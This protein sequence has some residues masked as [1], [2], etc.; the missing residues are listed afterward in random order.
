MR[1]GCVVIGLSIAAVL[2]AAPRVPYAT[3]LG[4]NAGDS[5]SQIASDS[6]GNYYVVS[7][8]SSTN[9]PALPANQS[10]GADTDVVVSKF[11]AA[12]VLVYSTVLAGN[13][14][15]SCNSIVADTDGSVYLGCNTSSPNFP[16]PAGSVIGTAVTGTGVVKLNPSGVLVASAFLAAPA[17]QGIAGITL[18]SGRN[19]WVTGNTAGFP[20]QTGAIQTG[21]AGDLDIFVAKFNSGLTQMTYFTYLGSSAADGGNRIAVDAAGNVY[22]SAFGGSPSFP[23]GTGKAFPGSGVFVAKL[24]PA[25]NK[26][27]YAS[28][29]SGGSGG[30]G[31][32]VDGNDIWICGSVGPT[33][34]TTADA[35]QPASGGG[36]DTAL[37]RLSAQDGTIRYASYFGGNGNEFANSMARDPDGNIIVFGNTT[38]TDLR[39]T[40]DAIRATLAN[41]T[42]AFLYQ[43]DAGGRLLFSTY[44]GGSTG[45]NFGISVALDKLGN[46]IVFGITAATDFP[47]SADAYQGQF[48]GGANDEYIA[49][50]ELVG[51][52]DP[53]LELTAIQNA[54]SFAGGA[55][56][57]G[58]II[59]IYPRNVGP[60]G[61]V[62]A[63]LTPD[64]RIAT[65]IGAT[66]VLFDDVPSPM[67]YTIN[68][69]V[70]LVVPYSVQGKALTRVVVEYNGVKS[71]PFA[72]PVT[73]AAP[74]IFTALSGVGQAAALNENG[75]FNTAVNRATRG[76]IL[77]F[78]LTGEGQT[79]PAGVDGRLNEFSR[80]E[81]FPA[82]VLKPVVTIGGQP[83]EILFSAG[84]PNY[85]AGLMQFN[86]RIP[87]GIQP[88]A[89]VPLTVTIGTTA[90]PSG[91]TLAIQ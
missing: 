63:A 62:T 19:V 66:R 57:P 77:V 32:V 15:D 90:T 20:N 45:F 5:A 43:V 58:E 35:L 27:L 52:A 4:G 44:L 2:A 74:G 7:V 37:V 14:A 68:G 26:L 69:Q 12:N 88:G 10:F 91:V 50:I 81:D 82:P 80:L 9:F 24:D 34:T 59:T 3:Y 67:V 42:S 49:R 83:A 18:D 25:A 78:F 16:R 6:S 70:S 55:V 41:P 47:V 28:Y 23:T 87:Q 60:A 56:A 21:V 51:P 72:V 22:L 54:A 64:R 31:F 13:A 89:A 85:L 46:P 48:G 17:S 38:S 36:T 29:V 11:S 79:A 71:R 75:S 39:T 30:F 8:T 53:Y 33:F 61:L 86:V 40:P 73:A 1:I 84:A 76:S 65:L